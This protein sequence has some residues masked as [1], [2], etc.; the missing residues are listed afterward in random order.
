MYRW[1]EVAG[2][3]IAPNGQFVSFEQI[4]LYLDATLDT[5]EQKVLSLARSLQSG[6][7]T[8]QEWQL[9]MRDTLKSIH[10]ASSALA[11]GGWAQMS[12]AD[13]GRVGFRL[14]EQYAYLEKF[15]KQIENGYLLDGR[16]LNR[17]QLYAQSGRLTYHM[18]QRSEML[19]RGMTEE[20]NILGAADHCSECVSETARGWVPIGDLVL[21]GQRICMTNCRCHVGFR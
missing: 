3:Y 9:G 12:Q 18:V 20:Q 13:Y 10:L 1:N 8:L 16:F 21:V 4:R 19:I 5:S 11:K 14:K 2:R 17:V 6:K 15:A 7:I